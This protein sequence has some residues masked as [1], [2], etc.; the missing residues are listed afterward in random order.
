MFTFYPWVHQFSNNLSSADQI[1][2]VTFPDV[3][4]RDVLPNKQFSMAAGDF[5]D[6]YTEPGLCT[7]DLTLL[8][9]GPSLYVKICPLHQTLTYIEV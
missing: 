8:T 2:P 9:W 3:N 4:P 7:F 5:M 6:V 1:R